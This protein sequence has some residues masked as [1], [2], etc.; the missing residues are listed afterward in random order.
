[1]DDKVEAAP[2]AKKEFTVAD[3]ED[4][5]ER[6]KANGYVEPEPPSREDRVKAVI[7]HLSHA[8]HHNTPFAR[9]T[10]QEVKDLLG[11]VEEG[12]EHVEE[13]I[14]A[15]EDNSDL[16]KAENNLRNEAEPPAK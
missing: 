8:M 5:A 11:H 4:P 14:K 16:V 7:A 15:A 13:K 10:L 3:I 9:A 2:E 1:M 12:A 6:A